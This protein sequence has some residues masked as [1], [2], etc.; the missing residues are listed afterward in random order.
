MR[1][2]HLLASRGAG[3]AE[4]LV[5]DLA[6]ELR[7]RDVKVGIAFISRAA[8]LGG[9]PEFES[10]Y[11]QVLDRAA[12]PAFDLGHDCRRN[13]LIGAVRLNRILKQYRPD[14]LHIHLEYGLLFRLLL[15]PARILT[16]YTHHIDRFRR[17]RALFRLLSLTVDHFIAISR[18]TDNLLRTVAGDRVTRIVN[19]VRF[20]KSA[21]SSRAKHGPVVQVL[22]VGGLFPQKNYSRHLRIVAALL[23]RRP[24]LADKVRFLIA[25]DGP[26]RAGLER[27]IAMRGL[28]PAASLLGIRSDVHD[29][30]IR[31]DL[32]LMTSDYEGLPITL[33][34]ALHAGLPIVAT[35]VGGCAEVVD[36]ETNG[37]L[38]PL[39]DERALSD[40]LLRLIDDAEL[41]ASFGQE[42]RRKAR[43]FSIDESA[44]R[45]LTLYCELLGSAR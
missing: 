23:K 10:R 22:S 6:I 30:M 5:R 13:P 36:H 27:Q 2:L 3:G 25:G 19:A 21:P 17:G 32:L 1:V 8:D 35:D 7:Q 37:F 18:Q 31:S 45:H 41:R 26:E 39:E 24:D 15:W 40:Y 14:I 20:N 4:V 16:I 42:A 11:Q 28:A 43:S 44:E 33:I 38:A 9:S 34:E 12:I 29:L